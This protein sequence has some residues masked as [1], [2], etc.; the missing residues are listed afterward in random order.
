M[1]ARQIGAMCAPQPQERPVQNYEC[2]RCK[3]RKDSP[4]KTERPPEHVS[5]AERTE[6]EHVHAIRQD[7]PTAEE[8]DG[9]NGQSEI[10]TT[11]TTRPRCT[12]RRPVNGLRH[13]STPF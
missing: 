4:L 12:G 3:N 9:K 8:D 6:P 13:C 5:I 2:G 7:G 10:D 11:A 1:T